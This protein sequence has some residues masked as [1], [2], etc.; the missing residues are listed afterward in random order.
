MAYRDIYEQYKRR[1]RR[2][3]I[4]RTLRKNAET[5]TKYIAEQ[6]KTWD[7]D[8][9]GDPPRLEDALIQNAIDDM[10]ELLNHAYNESYEILELFRHPVEIENLAD[11]D[12]P[13]KY[14]C[15][16]DDIKKLS[17]DIEKARKTAERGY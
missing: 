3:F 17:L 11:V 12:K 15:S 10:Q 16:L 5:L 6:E 8:D 7:I 13:V 14:V 4:L 2:N 9:E 1:E